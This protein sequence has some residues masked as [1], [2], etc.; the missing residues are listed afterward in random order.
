MRTVH[1]D[2]FASDPPDIDTWH[3]KCFVVLEQLLPTSSRLV[4]FARQVCDGM[5]LVYPETDQVDTQ[6][7]E[8]LQ[9]PA[10]AGIDKRMNYDE[11]FDY[12]IGKIREAW[13]DVVRD[14]MGMEDLRFFRGGE[15]DLDTGRDA[16][17]GDNL[18]FWEVA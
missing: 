17:A 14:A 11:I 12:T 4:P 7:I 9:V 1:P 18:V 15:W 8:G 16:T 13:R 10:A 2:L 6:Y 5:G 3:H